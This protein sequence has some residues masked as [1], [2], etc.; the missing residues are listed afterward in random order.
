MPLV[1]VVPAYNVRGVAAPGEHNPTYAR[2][3]GP[4]PTYDWRAAPGTPE[5]TARITPALVTHDLT[6]A[7]TADYDTQSLFSCYVVRGIDGRALDSFPRIRKS[8]LPWILSL[9]YTVT[10]E[11][12]AADIDNAG[13]RPWTENDRIAAVYR[14]GREPGIGVYFT[15]RGLRILQPI[16]RVLAA[17]DESESAARAW[18]LGIAERF[19]FSLTPSQDRAYCD[20]ACSDWTRLYFLPNAARGGARYRSAAI[21]LDGMRPVSPPRGVAVV[22]RGGGAARDIAGLVFVRVAPAT[23]DQLIAALAVPVRVGGYRGERHGLFLSLAGALLGRRVPPE[24]VPA[25]VWSVASVAGVAS[26]EHHRRSAVDTVG[27]WAAGRPVRGRAGLP[28]T[29]RDAFDVATLR[30]VSGR[31]RAAVR[32]E[33]IAVAQARLLGAIRDAPIGLTVVSTPCGLG[34]TTAAQVVAL[35]RSAAGLRTAIAVPT[36]KKSIE[37]VDELRGAGVAVRRV[38]GQLSLLDTDGSPVCRYAETAR[39]LAVGGQSIAWEFCD[40]RR[41]NPCE[42]RGGCAAYAGRDGPDDALVFVGPH[43]LLGELDRR[44]GGGLLIVDET[45]ALTTSETVSEA[46]LIQALASIDL[47]EPEYGAPLALAVDAFQ[48]WIASAALRTTLDGASILGEVDAGLLELAR[49]A[50]GDADAGARACVAGAGEAGGGRGDAPP[51]RRGVAYAA[52]HSL[53]LAQQIGHASR[54]LR[55]VRDAVTAGVARVW[56][57]EI[58][59]RGAFNSGRWARSVHDAGAGGARATGDTTPAPLRAAIVTTIPRGVTNALRRDGSVVLLDASAVVHA[60]LYRAVVG[61][62]PPTVVIAGSDS[63]RV[64]RTVLYTRD[65]VRS[66]GLGE[67]AALAGFVR[68]AVEWALSDPT[69]HDIGFVSTLA[70]E[71]I[72]AGEVRR[73]GG[74][75]YDALRLLPSPPALGHYGALRGLNAFSDLDALITIGDPWPNLAGVAGV[76]SIAGVDA[77]AYS[78]GLVEAELEQAHGRIRTIHRRRPARLLHV[79]R[80]RPGGWAEPTVREF[81]AF[82]PSVATGSKTEDPGAVA[83]GVAAGPV[84]A[85]AGLPE[86][87]AGMFERAVSVAGSERRLAAAMG[88]GWGAFRRGKQCGTAQFIDAVKFYIDASG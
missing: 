32:A 74:A 55:I 16:S 19:D 65:A 38:F 68:A 72:I 57:D 34:K 80:V 5:N 12:F 56:V 24:H 35:G 2:T 58:N 84:G 8:G 36:H 79:G 71:R 45:P 31:R 66:R 81:S 44:A 28:D 52:R 49:T 64:E 17:G 21:L 30:G 33:P 29:V 59:T 67:Y 40:G 48:R 73:G 26:P 42:F 87:F 77:D 4:D 14:Y 9:G 10:V 6:N 23:Y 83:A 85:A 75:I 3:D 47:F 37:I 78:E 27:E 51:L 46:D 20:P 54:V 7:L 18:V 41:V 63:G 22:R 70:V 11:V 15:P 53:A 25:I 43:A 50:V 86:A 39:H 76:A 62:D 69:T 13:K 82:L 60:A 61:Y 88:L 1:G